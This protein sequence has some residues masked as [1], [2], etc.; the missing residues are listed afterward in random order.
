MCVLVLCECVRAICKWI[1]IQDTMMPSREKCVRNA[2]IKPGIHA[3]FGCC[4]RLCCVDRSNR[5]FDDMCKMCIYLLV[6][7]HLACVLCV[8]LFCLFQSNDLTRNRPYG[9]ITIPSIIMI[10]LLWILFWWFEWNA[11]PL[12][13]F[14]SSLKCLPFIITF[15]ASKQNRFD[16]SSHFSLLFYVKSIR[17]EAKIIPERERERK[18]SKEENQTIPKCNLEMTENIWFWTIETTRERARRC[19]VKFISV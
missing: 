6:S 14:N 3:N 7:S 19:K 15:R 16:F 9:P 17:N 1:S 12:A 10:C 13:L 2:W 11:H 8:C 18:K 4:L 5:M